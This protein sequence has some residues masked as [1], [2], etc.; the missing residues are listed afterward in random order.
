MI[1]CIAA[2]GQMVEDDILIKADEIEFL[3][4]LT[5]YFKKNGQIAP[6]S[7]LRIWQL[8]T[9]K[10]MNIPENIATNKAI[11]LLREFAN[12]LYFDFINFQEELQESLFKLPRISD[13]TEIVELEI[14][15]LEEPGF[16]LLNF[17][18]EFS[19][20]VGPRCP[21]PKLVY[22]Q[23]G[24]FHEYHEIAAAILPYL[25]T[26]FGFLGV[27]VPIVIYK[28]QQKD[29]KKYEQKNNKT[30]NIKEEQKVEITLTTQTINN[31]PILFPNINT[32][33]SDTN[34]ITTDVIKILA[35]QP[36]KNSLG[37]N[38]YSNHNIQSITINFH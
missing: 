32:I 36:V 20:L 15:Y 33:T 6:I 12:M 23:K 30:S 13:I 8:L 1:A 3:K 28:K 25:Q 27:V 14:V 22:T 24:S 29:C 26:L 16:P 34:T 21:A 31:S 17:L 35:S 7:I 5:S 9:T 10:I 18:K 19:T 4:N 11:P 38:G 37:R 2:L